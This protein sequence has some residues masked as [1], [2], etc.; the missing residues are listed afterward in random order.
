MGFGLR[1]GLLLPLGEEMIIDKAD[2]PEISV[3]H[4]SLF[5]VRVQPVLV[6][7]HSH[8]HATKIQKIVNNLD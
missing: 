3:K 5:L 4:P 7:P 1:G 8:F 2:V 6:C